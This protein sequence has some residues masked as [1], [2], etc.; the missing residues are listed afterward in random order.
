MKRVKVGII[1]T[2]WWADW[3]H[4]PSLK[5]HEKADLVAICG[6]NQG[7]T[8]EIA[9]KYDIRETYADY[10]QM[11]AESDLDAV[12]ILTPDDMHYPMVMAALEK[13]LHV[14]CEKPLA[15]NAA[16]AAEML[17]KAEE[18]NVKHMVFFTWRWF[19][20]QRYFRRLIAEGSVGR[21][22]YF[23]F[24]FLGSGGLKTDRPYRW[25][26]DRKRA[27]GV[28]GDLGSHMI[29]MCR[30]CVDEIRSVSASLAVHVPVLDPQQAA[31]PANDSAVLTVETQKGTQGTIHVSRV[32]AISEM[33]QGL[34][35]HGEGGVLELAFRPFSGARITL[36][37]PG[38]P[39]RELPLPTDLSNEFDGSKPFLE[40]GK[41]V[42][43]EQPV[44]D[45]LFIDAILGAAAAQPSFYDG[46]RAQQVVDAAI[47]SAE[48]GRRI[49]LP[50]A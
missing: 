30:Y 20:H 14:M 45:R 28:L 23:H 17:Q 16:Q 40:Q 38:E 35:V 1:G 10:R 26:D 19:A 4:L 5:S 9:A 37:Q 41:Q 12:V 39:S 21:C 44:G 2:S 27:R 46:Y 33:E 42:F 13:R 49:S 25:R 15:L 43:R 48:T 47:E 8:G 7:R 50:D 36:M 3:V 29:D 32:A 18:A 11:I 6:R 24:H 22:L 34:S 31:E